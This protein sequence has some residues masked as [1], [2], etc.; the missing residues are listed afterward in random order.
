MNVRQHFPAGEPVSVETLLAEVTAPP[1]NGDPLSF[2]DERV[3]DFLGAV[4]R[5]LL[6][7][8]VTR[9]HPE[10]GALGFFLRPTELA[11]VVDSAA[12][13]SPYR[14]RFPRG[15]VFHIPPAN[16]DTVFVYSWALSALAGNA[17]VVRLSTRGGGASEVI[18]RVLHDAL[19]E[20]D[21]AVARTQRLVG[22]ERSDATTQALSA[23]CDLRVVW[24]GDASVTAV[25]R[26]ALRPQARDL[27]FPDRSS[28]AAISVTGWQAAGPERRRAAAEGLAN[29][30]YWFDQAA[31]SSPRTLF[32]VGEASAA[33][34][35][36]HEFEE[37][38]AQVVEARG[39]TVD[40]AM[41]VEKRVGAYGMAA[42]GAASA[43]RFHGNTVT[44]LDLA[45]P[46]RLPRRWLGAG[47]FACAVVDHLN[48]LIPLISRKDQTLS[49]FGFAPA[50]LRAFAAAAGRR[51]V[52]RIVPV[53]SALSFAATWDGYDLL[54]EFTRVMTISP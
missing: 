25:R 29:D 4:S 43:I 2:G 45:E 16:V 27:T 36:R 8:S 12:E 9:R 24:G 1:V 26:H 3:R 37:L 38:L 18:L 54:R 35:A 21:P 41:A 51:G 49:T 34:T 7:P 39:F 23:A 44:T 22:Y 5:R 32:W 40:A 48:D 19:G 13:R 17:N 46:A 53:G 15:L 47:T 28:L 42:E 52:D 31:C 33:G 6:K 14:L 20:A 30:A 50:T 10:L 11:R